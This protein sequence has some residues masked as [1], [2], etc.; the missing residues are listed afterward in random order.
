MSSENGNAMP[1]RPLIVWRAI[2]RG[3]SLDQYNKDGSENSYRDIDRSRLMAFQLL[4]DESVIITLHLDAGSRLICRR[5]RFLTEGI[6]APR[7][8]YMVGWQRTDNG[9]NSQC[10]AFVTED[11]QIH[12]IGRAREN[13]PVF[14]GVELLPEEME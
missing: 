12:L 7:T 9:V 8:C 2:Y 4:R 14:Y 1:D 3:G 5:R 10:M 11:G 13:H 6:S